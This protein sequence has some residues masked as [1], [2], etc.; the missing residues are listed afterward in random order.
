MKKVLFS[1]GVL[2]LFANVDAMLNVWSASGD[3]AREQTR[4]AEGFAVAR[5]DSLSC[6]F[7]RSE[8]G[9]GLFKKEGQNDA[10][11]LTI[12]FV[13]TNG[14]GNF[15]QTLSKDVRMVVVPND[16]RELPDG[17]FRGRASLKRISFEQNSALERIGFCAFRET[18]VEEVIIPDSVRE[19]CEGCFVGCRNLRRVTFGQNSVL[20]R[21]E[22]Y[23]FKE[24]GL[25][26]L[27]IPSRVRELGYRCFSECIS[28]IRVTFGSVSQLERI[29]GGS[30][31]Y[32][33][34]E[35]VAIP[36]SVIELRSM[37]FV[38]C[39]NLRRVTFGSASRLKC[40][41][42]IVF[43]HT[44]IESLDIPD[45]VVEL[46]E[47]CFYG[48]ASLRRITFGAGSRLERV[49]VDAYRMDVNV[50][51]PDDIYD[52]IQ[53]S[54]LVRYN[55]L[56]QYLS[57]L[58]GM[59]IDSVQISRDEPEISLWIQNMRGY[60]Y[61]LIVR[62]GVQT[63]HCDLPSCVIFEEGSQLQS[64]EKERWEFVK[65]IYLLGRPNWSQEVWDQLPMKPIKL[66]PDTTADVDAA[67][68]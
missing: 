26:E 52:I 39:Q 33:N 3:Q 24:T 42:R 4:P 50:S 18:G 49:G 22:D 13:S 19:L 48:C 15:F 55:N 46:C 20:D 67:S 16:V 58:T 41:G 31:E 2:G 23:T 12:D 32:T 5:V 51:A 65:Q 27:H 64:V 44:S 29:G 57:A 60:D 68:E 62:A 17:C 59:P 45:S 11:S 34:I 8:L 61:L 56:K 28:L 38:E 35:S 47:E 21:I 14:I 1:L 54:D 40:I 6:S 9:D 7:E 63:I 43:Y 66:Y 25:E 36:D 37:C 10:C 53:H 30:F